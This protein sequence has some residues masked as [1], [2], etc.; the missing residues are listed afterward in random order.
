MDLR[1]ARIEDGSSV[2]R[3][4]M[5]DIARA[6]GVS[7][8]TVSL[9]LRESPRLR[10]AT[11]NRVHAVARELG[12]QPNP[13]AASLAHFRRNS[14]TKPVHAALAWL[15]LWPE[16][17]QVRR[18]Q[19]F[20]L[21]RRGAS[22]T[23]QK[24]GYH[25]DDFI[26]NERLPPQRLQQ[27]LITRN[28]HGILIPPC[29]PSETSIDWRR[30]DWA[31]FSIIR[32]DRAS[33][34]LPLFKLVTSA[35]AANAA[36]AFSKILENGYRRIGYI[37]HQT[38]VRT[39]LGGFLQAQAVSLPVE[40]RVPP[41]LLPEDPASEFELEQ[42]VDNNS[43]RFMTWVREWRLDSILTESPRALQFIETAGPQFPSSIGLAAVN[44]LDSPIDAG[45]YQ[46]PEEIGRAAVLAVLSLMSDQAHGV[47][48]IQSE[49]LVKGK[50]VD[51]A[52]LPPRK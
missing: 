24:F 30:F 45:I 15:S 3:I 51:G 8:A 26:V 52:S 48:S 49:I 20:D 35:Q 7:S 5:R 17:R 13:M 4:T 37:G 47:D 23:A 27:I 50:W 11:R 28:I 40:E 38:N 21:Y 25:L 14:S 43:E 39:Y 18:I 12:Y 2:S 16:P 31:R 1:L 34:G 46:N 36:L 19:E 42:N 9:A 10:E 6:S 32:F 22:E 44:I 33:C 29:P 41:M